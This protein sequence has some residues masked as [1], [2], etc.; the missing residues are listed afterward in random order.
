MQPSY[1]NI[2]SVPEKSAVIFRNHHCAGGGEPASNTTTESS[3]SQQGT[4]LLPQAPEMGTG[5]WEIRWSDSVDTA[6]VKLISSFLPE[7]FLNKTSDYAPLQITFSV[8]KVRPTAPCPAASKAFVVFFLPPG[9]WPFLDL[10]KYN[11]HME[12]LAEM[13]VSMQKGY[14]PYTETL[15]S[16]IKLAALISAHIFIKRVSLYIK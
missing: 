16:V 13:N 7:D 12:K 3:M 14:F 10:C 6:R 4:T 9:K 8:S 1:K 15:L 5:S 11:N 2:Q